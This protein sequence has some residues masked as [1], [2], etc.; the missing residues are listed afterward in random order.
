M[1]AADQG[2]FLA[3][4]PRTVRRLLVTLLPAHELSD[5]LYEAPTE[6]AVTIARELPADRA[7]E[8]LDDVDSHTVA[9][10]LQELPEAEA[11]AIVA[12]LHRPEDVVPLLQYPSDTAGGM[13]TPD[14]SSLPTG[15]HGW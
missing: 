4:A 14:F 11:A 10:I 6:A 2:V 15:H 13:M 9:D 3:R 12:E 8:L 1:L 7:A 5:I